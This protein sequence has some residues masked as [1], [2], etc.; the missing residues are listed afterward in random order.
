MIYLLRH[1]QIEGDG[2][3]RFIGWT[4]PPLSEK[5]RETARKW[6]DALSDIAFGE[7]V[8]SDLR[9]SKETATIIAAGR[10]ISSMPEFREIG[11]GA[12]DGMPR[13]G[14]RAGQPDAWRQRGADMAGFRP[15]GG[16]SFADLS[17]RVLPSFHRIAAV[18]TRQDDHALIVGHA[19]V[20]RLILCHLLGM[21]L[22]NMFRLGQDY[23]G[24]TRIRRRGD[25]FR[26]EAMNVPVQ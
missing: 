22:E 3:R 24:L 15:P 12:W 20:N 1:G 21:N 19:G 26:V 16:E 13:D 14:I 18:Y 23:G 10:R 4:D 17:E 9:R 11:L 7:I 5:G 25:G 8:C 6:R 2:L